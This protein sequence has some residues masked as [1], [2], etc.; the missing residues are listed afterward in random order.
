MKHAD[1]LSSVN[2]HA[3]SHPNFTRRNLRHPH[4]HKSH[5]TNPWIISLDKDNCPRSHRRKI[6]LRLLQR[7]GVR[8]G[9]LPTRPT[10]R[11][12]LRK[13]APVHAV[14]ALD[15][16]ADGRVPAVV[17]QRGK[18]GLVDGAVAELRGQG[19]VVQHFEEAVGLRFQPEARAELNIALKTPGRG[20][21][22]VGY[23]ARLVEGGVW[24]VGWADGGLEGAGEEGVPGG[25]AE[26]FFVG[27]VGA[28]V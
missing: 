25:E 4:R 10:I 6:P 23:E 2:T 21:A 5:Q 15:A 8:H 11:R 3:L 27:G 14:R 9:P 20:F 12:P 18:V 13:I 26:G 7:Q 17:A 1:L 22:G 19:V 28:R 16:A 24:G